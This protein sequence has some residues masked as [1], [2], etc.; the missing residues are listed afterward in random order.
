MQALINS[1]LTSGY[2]DY[3]F[4]LVVFAFSLSVFYLAYIFIWPSIEVSRRA[5][6]TAGGATGTSGMGLTL[7]QMAR[8]QDAQLREAIESFYAS[9]QTD[10]VNAISRRLIRA[11]YFRKS[12]LYYFYV[13]R[14]AASAIAFFGTF[15]FV[16]LLFD[17]IT[18]AVA[19]YAGGASALL[20]LI[21]PNFVLDRLGTRQEERYRRAFPDFMDI[22]IVCADAGLS[23]EAGV[24]RVAGEMLITNREFGIHLNIMMLEVRAGKRLRE[25]LTSFAERLA[26]DEARSLATVFK[27]SE[28]L[29]A[30]ITDTLRVFSAEMRRARITRAE[31]KANKLPVKMIF[32]L[33]LFI[34]PVMLIVIIFPV[35]LTLLKII[36]QNMPN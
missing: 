5:S 33:G 6:A 4:M 22:L 36:G 7:P 28:E 24:A 35:M 17:D 11:G 31:E 15:F 19:G 32:P 26:L 9:L 10:D 16:R 23:L 8:G 27:Q 1:I 34:F 3:I 13:I 30:S 25:A 12:A 29:G 21:I 14:I 20:A 18:V 2:I